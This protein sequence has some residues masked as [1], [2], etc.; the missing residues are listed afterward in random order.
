MRSHPEEVRGVTQV[1]RNL[2]GERHESC[3]RVA[4]AQA[5]GM[6]QGPVELHALA[7][8]GGE[9]AWPSVARIACERQSDRGEMHAH[10]VRPPRLGKGGDE[11]AAPE[12][13]EHPVAR[14]RRLPR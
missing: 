4:D 5:K 12:P 13:L 1:V 3:G 2:G 7:L 14:A 11:R 8:R 10:L 9:E 6:E